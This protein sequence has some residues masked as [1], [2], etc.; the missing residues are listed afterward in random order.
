MIKTSARGVRVV[1]ENVRKKIGK[2]EKKARFIRTLELSPP[3][4]CVEFWSER[5]GRRFECWVAS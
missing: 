5:N 2:K 1:P 4:Y 3:Q